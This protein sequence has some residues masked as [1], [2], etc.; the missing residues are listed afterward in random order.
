MTIAAN[1][2]DYQI[3]IGV[4]STPWFGNSFILDDPT[5]GLLD[6]IEYRLGGTTLVDISHDVESVSIS[7]GRSRQLEQ[8]KAGT[9]TITVVD[10][11]RKYDPT[12]Q[13]SDYYQGLS[14]RQ[15]VQII[16]NGEHL[17]SGVIADF[18]YEYKSRSSS[19]DVSLLTISCI[20]NF[21][22]LG[23]TNIN[24]YTPAQNTSGD[25]VQE[26]L[27]LPEV[28]YAGN[29][30]IAAGSSTLGAYAITDN[31]VAIDYLQDITNSEKGYLF[32][33]RDGT[34]TFKGRNDLVS[35]AP[36]VIFA[37]EGNYPRYD[38]INV[39][40]GSEQLY[41]RAVVT[42]QGGIDQI[43]TDSNSV[44]AFGLSTYLD[45]NNLVSSD[46]QALDLAKYLV[47][48]FGQTDLRFADI[49]CGVRGS[50]LNDTAV[51][52]LDVSDIVSV[53]KNYSTGTPL[54][55]SETVA[56]EGIQHDFT[57]DRHNIKLSLGKVDGRSFMRLDDTTYGILDKNLLAF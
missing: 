53:T 57:R 11:T 41:N 36:S 31:A 15:P 56:I 25:R 6:S 43:A 17:F 39:F 40:F 2:L 13:D 9:C 20:D 12:N 24:G 19:N 51:L 5:R 23:R 49:V 28:D 10:L 47:S 7:R 50:G 38:Q 44:A 42:R 8:F 32:V 27:N 33:A 52:A 22:Y 30:S 55:R 46:D 35:T 29:L 54:S 1:G 4:A 21:D 16:V 34:L 14:P 26:I 18:D 48:I 3:I 45:S 37:D